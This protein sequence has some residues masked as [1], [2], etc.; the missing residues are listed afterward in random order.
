MRFETQ[1]SDLKHINAF[2]ELLEVLGS[3][4]VPLDD[5]CIKGQ[6]AALSQEVSGSNLGKGV[7]PTSS[8]ENP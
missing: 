6:K 5:H 4:K 8:K 7:K 1:L 3:G 2:V